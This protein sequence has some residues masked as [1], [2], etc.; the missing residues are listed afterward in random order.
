MWQLGFGCLDF[1]SAWVWLFQ[2]MWERICAMEVSL[3]QEHNIYIKASC[4]FKLTSVTRVWFSNSNWFSIHST[5]NWNDTPLNNLL[6]HTMV[7]IFH[8]SFLNL[9]FRPKQILIFLE[10]FGMPRIIEIILICNFVYSIV[11]ILIF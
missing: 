3:E 2:L 9:C 1:T 7:L 5:A 6:Q 8:L 4:S 11:F 10:N